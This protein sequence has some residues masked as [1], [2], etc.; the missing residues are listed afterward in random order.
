MVVGEYVSPNDIGG[1]A[2]GDLVWPGFVGTGD[3]ANVVGDLVV[4]IFVGIFVVGIFVDAEE[5]GMTVGDK[6]VGLSVGDKEDIVG[7]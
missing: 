3:G 5:V 2:V 6:D 1:L 7:V 4:G